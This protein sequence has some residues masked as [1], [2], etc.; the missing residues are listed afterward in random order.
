MYLY[1]MVNCKLFM[2]NNICDTDQLINRL[3]WRLDNRNDY[4][5]MLIVLKISELSCQLLAQIRDYVLTDVTC[6]NGVIKGLQKSKQKLWG[7]I[8]WD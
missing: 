1:L 5:H 3:M 8:L 4:N 2:N 6:T 7:N